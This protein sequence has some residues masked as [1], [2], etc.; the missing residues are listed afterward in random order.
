[1][2]YSS[3]NAHLVIA[4]RQPSLKVEHPKDATTPGLYDIEI[5]SGRYV[6]IKQVMRG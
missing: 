4:H 5:L 3:I 6:V 2:I 1:M